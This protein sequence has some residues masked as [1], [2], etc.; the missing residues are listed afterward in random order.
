MQIGGYRLVRRIGSGGM[1][2]VHEALDAEDRRVALKLLHPQISQDPSARA[3][4]AREVDLLHRVRGKGVARVL[5]AEID[6]DE[7]F[8]VTELIDGP[9]LEE[10]VQAHGPFAPDEL[11]TLAHGLAD[12]LHAIHRVGVV[13]RDLK[14]GNVMLSPSGPVIIDFGIAQV[15]DDARLTQTGMVAGT[16]GYLDP[17][18]IDGAPPTPACDWWAWAAVLV[19][20]ATGR[21]PFGQGPSMAIFKRMSLCEVDIDGVDP[22]VGRAL[23]AALQPRPAERLDSHAVLAVLDG[24]WT[25]VDLDEAIAGLQPPQEP[26]LV[27]PRQ[28]AVIPP[29][30]P[31]RF[32]H[33][34]DPRSAALAPDLWQ[35]QPGP[36]RPV[37]PPDPW[38]EPGR[39]AARQAGTVAAVAF[40]LTVAAAIWPGGAILTLLAVLLVTGTVGYARWSLARARRRH[41]PRA[42]DSLR[43]VA[44]SP[45]FLLRSALVTAGL[46]ALASGTGWVALQLA[47]LFLPVS[48][49]VEPVRTHLVLWIGAAAAVLAIW[50]GPGAR[51]HREGA[52]ALIAGLLPYRAMRL[53]LASLAVLLGLGFV[54]AVVTG[55]FTEPVWDPLATP[56]W[57]PL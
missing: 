7:V 4:L 1:G 36:W 9:T 2:T 51:V 28:P 11:R 37:P 19:F 17:Q 26:T 15:A 18:V 52:R 43:T 33:V 5:D 56:T 12:A 10:D 13:H 20:A 22:L 39:P 46:V 50:F 57:L 44:S 54:I 49:Q 14:P 3:R 32:E 21:R 30:S 41:G 40:L 42:G 6:D 31:T 23:Q 34:S 53:A 55:S 24:R 8:V 35:A 38:Q 47:D 45:W 48:G 25:A 27:S 29:L 16:P